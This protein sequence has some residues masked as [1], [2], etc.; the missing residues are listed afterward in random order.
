MLLGELQT[1]AQFT[2]GL[3]PLRFKVTRTTFE[4]RLTPITT[5]G[6]LLLSNSHLVYNDVNENVR[7]K[8]EEKNDIYKSEGCMKSSE[9]YSHL[10]R[11]LTPPLC[12]RG[13]LGTFI[14]IDKELGSE[15]EDKT[16]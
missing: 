4:G 7:Q 2:L 11:S 13:Y 9:P 15:V 6:T 10:S 16:W 5:D 3:A 1:S 14:I 8:N 12:H